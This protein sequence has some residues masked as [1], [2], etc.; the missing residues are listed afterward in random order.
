MEN[1]EDRFPSNLSALKS[2]H[3]LTQVDDRLFT[4]PSQL[5]AEIILIERSK[6]LSLPFY[7]SILLG[8]VH[9][10]GMIVPVI[11]ARLL[12]SKKSHEIQLEGLKETLSIVRLGQTAEHLSG[13]G[14]VVD[15]IVDNISAAQI[16]E[17]ESSQRQFQLQDI[18]NYVWQPQQKK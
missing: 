11:S 7:S 2:R 18:P 8:V 5:V 4:F 1:T 15:R 12:L 14:I 16:S 13:V 17:A 6:I 9:H 3:L 10:Q